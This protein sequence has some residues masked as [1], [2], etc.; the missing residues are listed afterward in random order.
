MQ[1]LVES[2][3]SQLA[4]LVFLKRR[5]FLSAK[6]IA[7]VGVVPVGGRCLE[8]P[9]PVLGLLWNRLRIL[10]MLRLTKNVL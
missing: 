10:V 4:V 7:R 9:L 6:L 5:K 8:A 2:A 1:L 3:R